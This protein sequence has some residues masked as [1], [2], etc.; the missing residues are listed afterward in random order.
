M[1]LLPAAA[2][3]A[4]PALVWRLL[5][6]RDAADLVLLRS[7]VLEWVYTETRREGGTGFMGRPRPEFFRSV[8]NTLRDPGTLPLPPPRHPAVGIR[9]AIAGPLEDPPSRPATWRPAP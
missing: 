1:D 7:G 6:P 9:L 3:D 5:K 8:A 4:L 2:D